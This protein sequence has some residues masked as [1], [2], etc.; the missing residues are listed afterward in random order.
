MNWSKRLQMIGEEAAR[1]SDFAYS[2]YVRSL[3]IQ[4]LNACENKDSK[5]VKTLIARMGF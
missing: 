2:T 1:T 3:Y 5:R 4:L